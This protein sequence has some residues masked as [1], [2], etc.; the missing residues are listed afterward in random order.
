MNFLPLS[1]EGLGR[2]GSDFWDKVSDTTWFPEYPEVI[3]WSNEARTLRF[4]IKAGQDLS[5]LLHFWGIHANFT[6]LTSMMVARDLY[7]S[8]EQKDLI[9]KYKNLIPQDSLSL[10]ASFR[11]IWV[12]EITTKNFDEWQQR[13]DAWNQT[14]IDQAEAVIDNIIETHWPAGSRK[15]FLRAPTNLMIGQ[16]HKS[17]PAMPAWSSRSLTETA[18]FDHGRN[19]WMSRG[20]AMH[21]K[22]TFEREFMG[23]EDLKGPFE[24]TVVDGV[25]T[26]VEY[27][28]EEWQEIVVSEIDLSQIP[29]IEGLFDF[30]SDSMEKPDD[31]VHVMYD[32]A[33]GYPKQI[34]VEYDGE[35]ED[36][37]EDDIEFM[38]IY[39][40]VVTIIGAEAEN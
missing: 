12:P 21:Y 13:A 20:P 33:T 37:S 35:D 32:A 40:S 9:L 14:M 11:E 19:K 7:P 27:A 22:F 3:D 16:D 23:P 4:S 28:R 15:L 1:G 30:I 39:V 25:V 5:P 36:E 10:E 18:D 31:L 24:V 17:P 8:Q 29:T 38:T 6:L 34:H 2:G 26:Q